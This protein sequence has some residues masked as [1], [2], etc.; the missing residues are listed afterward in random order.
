VL[1]PKLGDCIYRYKKKIKKKI[2]K[3]KKKRCRSLGKFALSTACL[4]RNSGTGY[5]GFLFPAKF[6]AKNCVLNPKLGDWEDV[7]ISWEV[8]N[9]HRFER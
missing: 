2:K 9:R 4:T 1:N 6:R 8:E 7:H 5:A 3:I